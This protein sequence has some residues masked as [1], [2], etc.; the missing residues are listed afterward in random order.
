VVSIQPSASIRCRGGKL[1]A[2]AVYPIQQLLTRGLL[3]LVYGD[4]ALD[5]LWGS[6][7]ASTEAIFAYLA[8]AL[9]PQRILLLGEVEGVYSV[10]PR[11]DPQA[12]VIPIIHAARVGQTDGTL[13]GSHGVDVTGGM[14]S[15]VHLMLELVRDLPGLTVQ[16]VSGLLPG[17]LERVLLDPSSNLG[18]RITV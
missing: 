3:P 18:T 11:K 15:K 14:H 13:G 17:L 1:A 9:H 6:T 5:E 12:H 16:L 8:R 4:V 7:I 10:D 2:M